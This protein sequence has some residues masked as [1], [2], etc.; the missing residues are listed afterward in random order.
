MSCRLGRNQCGRSHT[1]IHVSRTYLAHHELES[2]VV[3]IVVIIIII[4]IIIVIIIIIIIIIIVVV[5][6]VVVVIFVIFR[7]F[8]VIHVCLVVR[9][10]RCNDCA[11]TLLHH[12]IG[13]WNVQVTGSYE[14]CSVYRIGEFATPSLI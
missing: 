10:Q 11:G 5:V 6:V 13:W 14:G 2:V 7:S 4:I 1:I 8:I 12:T 9:I 3:I